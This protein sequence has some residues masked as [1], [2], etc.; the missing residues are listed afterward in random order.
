METTNTTKEI[1]NKFYEAKSHKGEW[2]TMFADDIT[3]KGTGMPSLKG[4]QSVIEITNDL[5]TRLES[6]AMK[7]IF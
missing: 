6:Y 3:F 2:Q 4:K 7:K 1:V 5:L